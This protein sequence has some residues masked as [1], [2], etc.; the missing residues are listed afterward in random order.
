MMHGS[1]FVAV[2]DKTAKA[3]KRDA[4]GD[5][6]K[7]KNNCND[8]GAEQRFSKNSHGEMGLFHPPPTVAGAP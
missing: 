1:W 6:V 4:C 2:G 8:E 3:K 5:K 7:R